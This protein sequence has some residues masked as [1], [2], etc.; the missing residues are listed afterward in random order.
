[1]YRVRP[2]IHLQRGD[3]GFLRDL[4]LAELPHLLLAF[5][6]LV[7]QLALARDVAAVALGGHVLAQ[8]RMVSRAM[9]LPPIAAWIGIWNMCGGIRSFSFSHM[10]RPRCFG[11]RAVD[12]HRERIDRLGIDEDRHLDEV[13][14]LVAVIW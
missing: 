1:L 9:T 8:A 10:A 7:Q 4:D 2:T 13:A 6:L 14:L 12:Q 5:L 11:A 3:E